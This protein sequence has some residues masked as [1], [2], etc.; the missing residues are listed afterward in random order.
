MQ[1]RTLGVL[2][3]TT[4][5]LASVATAGASTRTREP[6]SA[7]VAKR[8]GPMVLAGNTVVIV[9][10][11]VPVPEPESEPESESEPDPGDDD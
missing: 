5:L 9:P 8:T 6:V 7:P 1:S 10:V 11:P 3:A 4:A 2:L